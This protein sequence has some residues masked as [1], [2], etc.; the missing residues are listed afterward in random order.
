M[1]G[2]TTL[3]TPY[4]FVKYEGKGTPGI[5]PAPDAAQANDAGSRVTFLWARNG[6]DITSEGD[7]RITSDLA[8]FDV[9]ADTALFVGN[10]Q[11]TQDKNLL[12]GGRLFVDRKAGKSR[13]ETP[14]EGAQPAGRIAAL[15]YQ[16]EAKAGAQTQPKQHG[17][18]RSHS[19]LRLVQGRSQRTHRGRG[20]H[21]RRARR[22]QEG[23]LQRQRQGQAGRDDRAH[24]RAD[25]VLH[26]PRRLRPRRCQCGEARRRVAGADHAR[27]GTAQ[28]ADHL[29][30]RPERH[31]RL[32][33]LRRQVQHGV[34]R[35]RRGGDEGQGHRRGPQ[36]QDRPHH[37]HVSLRG[38]R[39]AAHRCS[40][41]HHRRR[42]IQPT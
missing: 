30:G 36:A 21:A 41:A 1:Q 9:K 18:R 12:V 39:A 20:R 27:G 15:F 26:G 17:R 14:P 22:Q 24:R 23:H 32:G 7:Q 13:L 28:G 8:D 25:R 3:K 37:R 6:V 16:A 4:L 33:Q 5:T 38:G 19:G 35:R 31:R 42:P 2:E 29:R 34:A 40:R 11:V 10:V